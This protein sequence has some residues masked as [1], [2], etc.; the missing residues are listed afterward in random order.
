MTEA[1]QH[2]DREAR[3]AAHRLEECETR[4]AESRKAAKWHGL[5]AVLGVSPASLVPMVGLGVDFGAVAILGAS[6]AVVGLESWRYFR[7]RGEL[8]DA[9]SERERLLAGPGG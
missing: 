4:I 1:I 6:A 8:R 3:I 7:A 9:E 2:S 5:F